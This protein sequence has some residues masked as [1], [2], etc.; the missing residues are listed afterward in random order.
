LGIRRS[1]Q[2]RR[3]LEREITPVETIYGVINVKIAK[4]KG[5]ILNIQPEYEDCV[6]IAQKYN[7]P[8]RVIHQ[9]VLDTI[10]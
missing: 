3:I 2:K 1:T 4:D 9:T 10:T 6:K 5:K 8:W 7:L